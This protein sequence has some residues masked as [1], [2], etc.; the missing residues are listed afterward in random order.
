M[1]VNDLVLCIQTWPARKVMRGM[2]GRVEQISSGEY[3]PYKILWWRWTKGTGIMRHHNADAD[4]GVE[5]AQPVRVLHQAH[6]LDTVFRL[7]K[8]DEVL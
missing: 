8:P 3:F 7:I 5:L 2:V 6:H 4:R 1:K